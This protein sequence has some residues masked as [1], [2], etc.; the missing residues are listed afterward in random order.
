MS[1]LLCTPLVL[2]HF[3]VRKVT[4]KL[5]GN[6]VS[7]QRRPMVANGF[8]LYLDGGRRKFVARRFDGFST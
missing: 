3:P 8:E 4:P 5:H 6:D 1:G 7:D 2:K